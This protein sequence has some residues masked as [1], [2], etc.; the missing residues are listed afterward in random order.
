MNLHPVPTPAMCLLPTVTKAPVIGSSSSSSLQGQT[1]NTTATT[2][3]SLKE[4]KEMW[5]QY[6]RTP[7]TG[8]PLAH[9]HLPGGSPKRERGLTRVASSPSVKTPSAA[10]AGWGDP[11]RGLSG[12]QQ[13][14][15]SGSNNAQPYAGMRGTRHTP[16]GTIT[17]MTYEATN[18]RCSI[19]HRLLFILRH[20]GVV[21]LLRLGLPPRLRHPRR[22]QARAPWEVAVG[23]TGV[24]VA[25][26]MTVGA[27]APPLH[28]VEGRLPLKTPR[29][30]RSS[31]Y[32]RRP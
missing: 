24:R 4:L 16:A 8:Q 10:T 27:L 12:N 26:R 15:G 18:K 25:S 17:Q 7:L 20:A 6:M 11:M 23:A 22:V 14:A 2:P 31:A 30:Q 19:A 32:R 1:G 29:V 3:G 21:T 28:L 9:E 13:V 5:K